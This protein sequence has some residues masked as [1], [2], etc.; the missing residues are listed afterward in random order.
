MR[1]R[2]RLKFSVGPPVLWRISRGFL[3]LAVVCFLLAVGMAV[4]RY[5]F[6]QRRAAW[7]R[8]VIVALGLMPSV[9]LFP[10]ATWMQRHVRRDWQESGG[11]LCMNCGYRLIGLPPSGRCPECGAAYD[12][13]ADAEHW[14]EI[15][16]ERPASVSTV[17]PK[18]ESKG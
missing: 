16:F 10:L 1:V 7:Q 14:R 4:W 2:R 3:A 8:H 11:R 18:N 15:G 13:D 17:T 6:A 5:G 9:V 12:L